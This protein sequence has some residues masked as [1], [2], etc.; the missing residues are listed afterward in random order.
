MGTESGPSSWEELVER[1]ELPV[2]DEV[3]RYAV[4]DPEASAVLFAKDPVL[5]LRSTIGFDTERGASCVTD[6]ELARRHSEG[7]FYEWAPKVAQ[8]VR[9]Y[10]VSRG[11][12]GLRG[13]SA[14]AV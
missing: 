10:L 9:A 3:L 14:D 13:S 7:G 12:V 5:W 4:V 1:V 6:V 2:S 11:F 8:A